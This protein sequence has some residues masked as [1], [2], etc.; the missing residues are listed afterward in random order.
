MVLRGFILQSNEIEA[1]GRFG[2]PTH[3][4][5]E[6]GRFHFDKVRI[7]L[8]DHYVQEILQ[9]DQLVQAYIEK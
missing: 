1:A 3:K 6:R 7:D 5:K 8:T 9:I 2:R 4:A